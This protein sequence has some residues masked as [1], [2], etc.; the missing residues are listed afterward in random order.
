MAPI[1][2]KIRGTA[3]EIDPGRTVS[4]ADPAM[5]ITSRPTTRLVLV[6]EDNA[7]D[8]RLLREMLDD[9]AAHDTEATYVAGMIEAELH[10]AERAFDVILLDLGLPDVQGLEAVRRARAAAPDVPLVVLTGFDDESLARNAL[11]QG[12]Q[13]YLV[14]GEV[15]SRGLLRAIRYA[16]ERKILEDARNAAESQLLQAQKLESIGRLAGGIAH[17]FNNMLFA[18]HGYAE[19]LT[20]DLA[21]ASR[22]RFDPDSA[23]RNVTQISHAADRAAALTAQLLAFSR[24]QMVTTK[25]LDINAAVVKIEPMLTQLIGENVQLVLK[26]DDSVGNI[27]A[28]AGQIDQIVVNLVVNARDAMPNGGTVTIETG[29]ALFEEPY[30]IDH[31]GVDPGAYVLLAISDNGMGMDRATRDHLFEPF[32]TTKEVGKGTGLGLATTYG[33]VHQAGGHIWVY[34]EP[35][36]GSAFKLYFPRMDLSP[37]EQP[38]AP[39]AAVMGVGTVMIVEDEPAVRDM[40]TQLLERAGYAVLAVAEGMEAMARA[41]RVGPIDVLITDVIMPNLSGIDLAGQM[42]DTYP[43]LG[44]VL[45]SGYTAETLDLERVTSRGA[46]FV[47]KPVT[48]NQLL[49]SILQ[50]AASRR[51]GVDPAKSATSR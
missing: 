50:A 21:P 24:Q 19:L 5:G 31:V 26:L 34:S 8:A 3:S 33:I 10:L 46:L 28:D 37:E 35:G 47:P 7:G 38:A 15:D 14:K 30:A 27:R 42:M 36:H 13:D 32:F 25:V 40:T 29:A 17:D 20:E 39:V 4:I 48:S 41:R 49:Q 12:A 1:P 44:V 16:I 6:I 2:V 9:H 22:A 23:L 43:L 45:L 51:A 18:I 11:H